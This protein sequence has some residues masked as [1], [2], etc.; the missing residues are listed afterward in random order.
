MRNL[1]A[2]L[3][4]TATASALSVPHA[5]ARVPP[6]AQARSRVAVAQY[7]VSHGTDVSHAAQAAQEV[8]NLPVGWTSVVDQAS[9]HPYYYHEAT[10]QTQW[11]FPQQDMYT[12]QQ[13]QLPAGWTTGVDQETG[14]VYYID[15]QTGQSQWEP[16]QNGGY[17]Q[18][19]QVLWRL[20]SASGWTPRFAGTY[21]LAAG[22]EAVLGR[23]DMHSD[24]CTRPW[25]SRKQCAVIVE[26]DGTAILVTRGKPPTGWRAPGG[27][28]N[29]LWTGFAN[30][31]Y[32]EYHILSDGDQISLDANDEE[33][34]VFTCRLVR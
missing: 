2:C 16:P 24:I 21:K 29:W 25:V 26:A 28:W 30:N 4:V 11:D 33:G 17:A 22:E 10:G 20:D 6:H 13:V 14:D 9:G 15:E 8:I 7:G 18:P 27:A 19:G 31:G 12:Q 34:S 3:A 5:R 32:P 1:L 23:Y